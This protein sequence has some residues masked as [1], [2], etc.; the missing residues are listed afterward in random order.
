MKREN[1]IGQK[2]GKLTVIELDEKKSQEKKKSV[3][4]CRCD[5][6][7]ILSVLA[8]NL[9]KGNSTK[10]KYCKAANLIGQKF[11]YLTV[12]ER[13][14]DSNDHVFWKCRCD[15]GTKDIEID[16]HNLISRGTQSCGCIASKGEEKISKI[17]SKNNIDFVREYLI[18][19]YKLST[20][21]YPRFDFAIFHNGE[22]KYFIEYQG[23]QHYK[24]RGTIFTD[25]KV[26]I[27]QQR[28]KEKL[29]YCKINNIPIV[30][31]NYTQYNNL[32]ENDIIRLDLIEEK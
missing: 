20:G 29:E 4:I 22:L 13:I 14:I 12:I 18:K 2:F 32:A 7:T 23:E 19:D 25:E 6:G 24:A 3:W 15:C 26:K 11:N 31:I 8:N 28:D 16:G 17:L 5:C 1:L 30:Y 9:K 10:C 27:I 21:G